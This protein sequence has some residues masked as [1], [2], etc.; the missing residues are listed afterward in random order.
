[1]RRSVMIT[2]ANSGIGL[3]AALLLARDHDVVGTVRSP[4]K[5][6]VVHEAADERGVAVRTV[7]C[8]VADAAQAATA[9]DQVA[10]LTDGGPW[11]LVNNAGFAQPG[12]VE[13][14]D[15]EAARHQLEVN[16]VA[17]MRLARLVLPTM[18]A[19]GD[20]R[21]VNVSSLV[22]RVSV[23]LMGWYCA[24]KKALEGV[25]DALRIEVA[26]HG[27]A[28]VLVEPGG[29]G[30]G[31]WDAAAGNL[32]DV[33]DSPYASAY[34]RLS[35]GV[36][37]TGLL[38]DP[39]WAAR[40]IRLSL[41]TPWPRSRYLVGV[42]AVLGAAAETLTPTPLMDYAKAVSTGLRQLPFIGSAG[43]TR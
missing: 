28:V 30:T 23:P 43:P 36:S 12:A 24:S 25:T 42:D 34:R 18:R 11:A 3:Q 31:I 14:V 21:I 39:V 33:T 37:T 17:P 10:A 4:Q 8:D 15:D 26:P 9:V 20:G 19:R 32:P 1:M 40:V 6:E 22:G 2:G 5:A 7:V 35:G 38:P 16:L 41:T 29:F 13:D 27:I